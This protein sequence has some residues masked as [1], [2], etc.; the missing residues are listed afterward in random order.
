MLG[1]GRI[2]ALS[3]VVHSSRI[4]FR[5][6]DVVNTANTVAGDVALGGSLEGTSGV[7][8]AGVLR[9]SDSLS[10]LQW[11]KAALMLLFVSRGSAGV[12]I[13]IPPWNPESSWGQAQRPACR[14]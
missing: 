7:P 10:L 11:G 13:T 8:E 5:I 14:T 4:Q 2:S 3:N 1:V 12:K 9:G 6:R